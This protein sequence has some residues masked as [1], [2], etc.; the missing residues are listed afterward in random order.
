MLG[1]GSAG[2]HK[3]LT[4]PQPGRVLLR[5]DFKRI[6]PSDLT[7]PGAFGYEWV[8]HPYPELIKPKPY[9]APTKTNNELLDVIGLELDYLPLPIQHWM[10]PQTSYPKP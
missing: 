6:A 3:C 1:T 7:K 10:K 4:K 8:Q 5:G 2:V 9:T